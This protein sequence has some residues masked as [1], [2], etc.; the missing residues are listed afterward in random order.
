[1]PTEKLSNVETIYSRVKLYDLK[2]N[3]APF[4]DWTKF[5]NSILKNYGS[6]EVLTD[7]DEIIV[8]GLDY[9]K[10]LKGIINE[11]QSDPE[12]ERILKLS[13]IFHFIKFSLP[14]LSKEYRNQF[15]ALGEALTGKIY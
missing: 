14:L 1:M 13:I 6:L 8:M 15:S 12:K 11:Y 10:G 5:L 2:N 3:Y 7:E 4:Y 9:F